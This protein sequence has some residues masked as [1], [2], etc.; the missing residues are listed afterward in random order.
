MPEFGHIGSFTEADTIQKGGEIKLGCVPGTLVLCLVV[1]C[2]LYFFIR[3]VPFGR[4]DYDATLLPR[5][6]LVLTE[7]T[8]N[9]AKALTIMGAEKGDVYLCASPPLT[10]E[11]LNYQVQIQERATGKHQIPF[12][13]NEDSSMTL[14]LQTRL[15][16]LLIRGFDSLQEF[17]TGDEDFSPHS[18]PTRT[19]MIRIHYTEHYFLAVDGRDTIS[20]HVD[21]E[22]TVHD[23]TD[24]EHV[25]KFNPDEHCTLELEGKPNALT[26]VLK[27][28]DDLTYWP[29]LKFGVARVMTMLRVLEILS[30]VL[31]VF[32]G[33]GLFF[34]SIY[35]YLNERLRKSGL[36]INE[37]PF[38]MPTIPEEQ[39][40]SV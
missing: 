19:D 17:R 37:N 35:W 38:E 25:C 18:R 4:V 31:P 8:S 5:T 32:G 36:S 24:C 1:G 16:L 20:G 13:L 11:K 15:G 28:S 33:G 40:L 29:V 14:N 34:Y 6:T 21:I 27:G 10:S 7:M 2:F 3:G 30:L 12:N 9:Y 26:P 22:A 23:L 39:E